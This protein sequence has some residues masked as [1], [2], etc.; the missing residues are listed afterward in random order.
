MSKITT[1]IIIILDTKVF[2]VKLR[3]TERG[4]YSVYGT[5]C[6]KYLG[7]VLMFLAVEKPKKRQNNISKLKK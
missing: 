1:E 3:K 5:Q 2:C 6:M 7:N 4:N